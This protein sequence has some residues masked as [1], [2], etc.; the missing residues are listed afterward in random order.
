MG[1]NA[2]TAGGTAAAAGGELD[3]YQVLGVEVSATPDEIKKA[4]ARPFPVVHPPS[5]PCS[6]SQLTLV[7]H[8]SFRKAALREHPDK[9]P[10]DIEG[11][12]K[13]FARIQEAYECLSDEQERAWYDDHREDILTGGGE[14]TTE[15][16]ASFFE[17]MRRGTAQPKAPARPGRGLQTQHLMK[18]FSTSAWSGYDDSPNGFYTTFRTLFSLLQADEVSWSSPY[19]YPSFGDSSCPTGADLRSFYRTWENFSTEKDFAWKDLYRIE[20]S[21]PRW[22]RREIEKENQRARQAAKRE[23]NEAVRVRPRFPLLRLVVSEPHSRGALPSSPQKLVLFVRRRDPRYSS[24]STSSA[25]E[26]AAA[27]IQAS[28]A[29]AARQRALE[30]EATAAAYAAQEWE[31]GGAA[32]DAVHAQWAELSE[33]EE[34][35]EDDEEAVW[36]EACGRGYRSGGAWEDHERSRKHVKNVERLIKEM[37]LEDAALGLGGTSTVPPEL[38]D[39]A[40]TASTSRSPSPSPS[41]AARL[42]DQLGG[43]SVSDPD[44]KKTPAEPADAADR[45]SRASDDENLASL[46]IARKG[47]KKTKGKGKKAFPPTG[48]DDDS[49]SDWAKGGRGGKKGKKGRRAKG[50]KGPAST[51]PAVFE[52]PEQEQGENV[53]E[54]DAGAKEEEQ[55]EDEREVSKKD[56]RRAK[57][58]AKKAA[59]KVGGGSEELKCNVCATTFVSRTKLFNHIAETG[60]ALADGA[61]S[62]KGG[63]KKKGKR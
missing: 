21:M 61:A 43:F 14:G 9:N 25:R 16:D 42:A 40:P 41:D 26:A 18:F 48:L 57:E 63:G 27:E 3:H 2:S 33:E 58:A 60:H 55:G 7:P 46:G 13:R 47:R 31:K 35:E 50:V 28:L 17:S 22:H 29:A 1:A 56:K 15:A 11:A 44:A 23:Y 39:H 53:E 30:R 12:T 36:C 34:G 49:D 38:D 5:P 19:L 62:V 24:T 4:C 10:D 37:Q 51:S 52:P 6:P 8:H 45:A 59:A 54:T 20:E 32:A